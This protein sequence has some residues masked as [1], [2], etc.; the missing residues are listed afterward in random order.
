[1]KYKTCYMARHQKSIGKFTPTYGEIEAGNEREA[2]DIA[3]KQLE[4]ACL[5]TAG[6]YAECM[7]ESPS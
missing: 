5:K 3:R 1:M 7:D 6:G 2:L 4:E